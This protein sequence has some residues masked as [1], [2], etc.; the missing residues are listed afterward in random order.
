M[1][2]K[3]RKDVMPL[4]AS[5]VDDAASVLAGIVHRTAVDYSSTFSE[6]TGSQVYFKTENLQ[7]TGSFKI[8]G[9]Y[10]KISRLTEA[11]RARGVITASAGN[12]AQGVA[13]AAARAGIGATV[14][15]P[16]T[17]PIAKVEATRGYG[18]EVVLAGRGYDEAFA[19]ARELQAK[20]GATFIHGFDDP[21]I[22]AG[23][24]TVGLEI[25]EQLPHADAVI[26]PVGGGGLVAGTALAVKSRRPAVKVIGV[27][28]EGAPAMCLS[29]QA[30]CLQESGSAC[31]LADGIAVRRPGR[32]TFE[33]VC[34]YVDDVVTVSDEEIARAIT[35]LLERSKLVVEGAGAAGLAALMQKRVV[36]P[37]AT[38]V[39]V[40]SGGNIDINT[41]SILIERG[42]LQSGRRVY[43]RAMVDDRPGMLQKLLGAIA[44]MQANIITVAH[45]RVDPRVPLKKAE[46]KLLLETRSRS[47][48]R[49]IINRLREIGWEVEQI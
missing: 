16:L 45:D 28:S 43:I 42:L 31:T 39:V 11:Q 3:E 10:Y 26:L 5:R 14:V 6:L 21:D 36:L 48:V 9:A 13:Y 2:T 35:M 49:D 38:V 23:Q 30:R 40:L 46:V 27:Q 20:T 47:H 44:D 29:H 17:A 1:E 22:I 25:L 18:A 15:M 32:L 4:S 19:E 37:G 12:H 8:R 24:G 7:K 41:V 34:R 33:L